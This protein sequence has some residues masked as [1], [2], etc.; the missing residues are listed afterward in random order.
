[1]L[2]LCLSTVLPKNHL[3]GFKSG[4]SMNFKIAVC[5]DEKIICSQLTEL[6][7]NAAE[8]LSVRFETDC[9]LS[10]EDLCKEMKYTEY[11]LIFLD[12][13]LPAMNGVNVGKYIRNNLH[14]E[15]IQIAYISSNQ[16]YAMELFETRPIH[17]LVKPIQYYQVKNIIE[18]LLYLNDIDTG[19]FKF[20]SGHEYHQISL[21]EIMY[22][23]GS[24]RKVTV[25]TTNKSYDFYG[26]LEKIYSSIKDKD[27]LYVH[28]S[29]IINYKYIEK[30]EYEQVTMVDHT[31]IPISQSRRKA[32]RSKFFMIGSNNL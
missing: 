21:S 3:T 24:G 10:G 17:F 16:D 2:F 27:F 25:T 19:L 7:G 18:K 5:D 4:D 29:Y 11:D 8:R 31:M 26:S 1:M 32:V 22:F 14:N 20:K 30:F 13:E 6:I 23:T 12:I 9:F 15:L 28:K